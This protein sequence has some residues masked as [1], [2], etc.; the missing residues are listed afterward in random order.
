[1]TNSLS[2]FVSNLVEEFCKIKCANCN[3][4]CLTAYN[5]TKDDLPEYKCLYCNKHFQKTFDENVRGL[6]IDINFL[7]MIPIS[8]I[9]LLRKVFIHMNTLII[10]ESLTRNHY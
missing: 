9:L 3:M 6:P 7:I 1:M 5:N 10:G 4:Y 8:F 2:I